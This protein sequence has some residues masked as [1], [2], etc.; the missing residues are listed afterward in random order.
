M[1]ESMGRRARDEPGEVNKVFATALEARK[2]L[3]FTMMAAESQKI[4]K[5]ESAPIRSVL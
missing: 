5:Q 3:D 2:S 1:E 4:L